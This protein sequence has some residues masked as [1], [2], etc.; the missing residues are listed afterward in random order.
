MF[1]HSQGKNGEQQGNIINHGESGT[2]TTPI[3]LPC[4]CGSPQRVY[5]HL[6]PIETNWRLGMIHG[7]AGGAHRLTSSSS[8]WWWMMYV[9]SRWDCRIWPWLRLRTTTISVPIIMQEDELSK[10]C[11]AVSRHRACTKI[12]CN[13]FDRYWFSGN[14]CDDAIKGMKTGAWRGDL[15]VAGQSSVR[16]GTGK[17]QLDRLNTN[18]NQKHSLCHGSNNPGPRIRGVLLLEIHGMVSANQHKNDSPRG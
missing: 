3:I 18:N 12:E 17:P 4:L 16:N 5:H 6:L 2:A 15:R 9:P 11:S 14:Y 1:L 13:E 10:T 8:P 7:Q